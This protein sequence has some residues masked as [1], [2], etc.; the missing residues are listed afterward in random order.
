M[1]SLPHL[2]FCHWSR[3]VEQYLAQ[4]PTISAPESCCAKNARAY[5]VLYDTLRT[6]AKFQHGS[7]LR[8][9]VRPAAYA[10]RHRSVHL[11]LGYNGLRAEKMAG[12]EHAAAQAHHALQEGHKG[13]E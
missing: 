8:L 7:R 1:R 12:V 13:E 11:Q 10:G 5:Q 9:W 6:H 4:R 3:N 2:A